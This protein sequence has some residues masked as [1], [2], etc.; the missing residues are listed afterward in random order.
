MSFGPVFIIAAPQISSCS[1]HRKLHPI[2][3]IKHQYVQNKDKKH[4]P[5]A[6]TT[7]DTLFG[8]VF[9][10]VASLPVAYFKPIYAKI[11]KEIT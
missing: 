8:P 1:V 2:Y 3:T 5:K 4:S 11:Q 6:Q 7:S 10:V 9:V